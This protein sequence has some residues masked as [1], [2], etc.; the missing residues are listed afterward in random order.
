MGIARSSMHKGSTFCAGRG[1]EYESLTVWTKR[2]SAETHVL[3]IPIA[4]DVTFALRT[5]SQSA[6]V[7]CTHFWGLRRE[8][9]P[10]LGRAVG[11]W[12]ACRPESPSE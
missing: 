12:R 6:C 10:L 9:W 4:R 11:F 5:N 3:G 2:T 1:V 7:R 8:R